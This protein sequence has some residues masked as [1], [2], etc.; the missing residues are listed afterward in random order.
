MSFMIKHYWEEKRRG[1][2]WRKKLTLKIKQH[3]F[4][5]VIELNDLYITVHIQSKGGQVTF[6]KY[7]IYLF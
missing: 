4:E 3:H 2:Q 1:E 7:L 5:D 6:L